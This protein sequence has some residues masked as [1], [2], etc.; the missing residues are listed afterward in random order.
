MVF[1]KKFNDAFNS[2]SNPLLFYSYS[3]TWISSIVGVHE[4]SGFT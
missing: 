4:A 3:T 1:I 2:S